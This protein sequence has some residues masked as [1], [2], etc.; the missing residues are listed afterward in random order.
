MSSAPLHPSLALLGFT[1]PVVKSGAVVF[2]VRTALGLT[3]L[4]A[5]PDLARDLARALLAASTSDAPAPVDGTRR[6]GRG[7]VVPP[8]R[9]RGYLSAWAEHRA[10]RHRS[11]TAAARAHGIP[12]AAAYAWVHVRP[13]S[14]LSALC[15]QHG[16][17]AA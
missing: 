2:G 9:L 11:F 17:K 5:S 10:G 13:A 15:A 4:V 3:D 8:D 6:D 1:P 7:A 16:I 12:P 14:A